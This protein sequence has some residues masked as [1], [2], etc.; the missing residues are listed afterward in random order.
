MKIDDIISYLE[1]IRDERREQANTATRIGTAMLMILH[2]LTDDSTPFIRKDKDDVTRHLL[3]LIAGAVIG[4][5]EDI[6]LNPDGSIVCGSMQVNGS[7]VFQELVFNHQNVLEGDTYFTDREIIE[8]VEHINENA[9]RLHFRQEY[10]E[11]HVTLHAGD[12][13]LCKINRLDTAKSYYSSWTR[14][15][16]C[17]AAANTADVTIYPD[18]NV[19][20]GKNYAPV[21]AARCIRWGNDRDTT[22]QNSFYISS[23]EGRFL[24]LQGVS[25]P[26]LDDTNYAAFIGLPPDIGILKDLPISNKRPY[27]YAQG[28]IVQD[29]IRIDYQGNPEYTPRDR[30]TWNNSTTYIRGYDSTAKGYYQDRVWWGGC[31]W[32][33]TVTCT[34]SEPRWNN[35]DWAV[36]IG[37]KNLQMNILSSKGD[38]FAAGSYWTT[39]LI[40]SVWQAEMNI[41]E[42][43]IGKDNI[44]WERL[45]NGTTTSSDSAW[46]IQHKAGTDGLTLSIDSKKDIQGDWGTDTKVSFKCTVT[47][48]DGT[49]TITKNYNINM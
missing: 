22:R 33:C 47:F 29:L 8:T 24:F 44:Y 21:A 20:G 46:N 13:L 35:T 48:P 34:N 14:V 15:D 19:P 1:Q 11:D 3:S 39:D 26:K 17:D 31:L 4:E 18:D 32:Q 42:A 38:F 30:G 40:A 49:G 37:G 36:L 23:E 25:A 41:S 5:S 7:A 28:L 10:D 45:T 6:K 9:Y 43:E 27:L 2:Y 12:I 16:S